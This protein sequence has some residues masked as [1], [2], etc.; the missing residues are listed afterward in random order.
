MEENFGTKELYDVNLKSTF[1]MRIS[2]REIEEGETIIHFDKIEIATLDT[3]TSRVA[4]VGGFDNRP[5]VI[6]EQTKQV[7]FSLRKGVMSKTSWALI[8]NSK[9]A[10]AA[11]NIEKMKISFTETLETDENKQVTLK[12]NPIKFCE[13]NKEFI[14]IIICTFIEFEVLK[15]TT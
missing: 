6:W 4:A 11:T 8:S 1:P 13:A 3:V 10:T 12:Y 7:N 5:Q 9:I 14:N 2:N 15:D